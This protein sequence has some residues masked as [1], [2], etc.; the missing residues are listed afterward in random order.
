MWG[1]SPSQP[2]W[3]TAVFPTFFVLFQHVECRLQF[4]DAEQGMAL[5]FLCALKYLK[6][7]QDDSWG[8]PWRSSG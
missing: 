3:A 7:P 6:D 5:G 2:F 8:L 4:P 1:E